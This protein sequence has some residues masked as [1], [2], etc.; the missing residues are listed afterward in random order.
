M[1]IGIFGDSFGDKSHI[2]ETATSKAWTTYIAKEFD[3]DNH[4]A[5]GSSFYYSAKLFLK[6]HHLYDKIIF[7]VTDP[8]RLEVPPNFGIN[9]KQS[10]I[11]SITHANMMAEETGNIVYKVAADYFFYFSDLDKECFFQYAAID[12][13]RSIRK[14]NILFLPCFQHSVDE[15]DRKNELFRIASLDET[16]SILE[17]SGRI[18]DT[19]HCHFNNQNN[20]IFA[21]NI[22][23]WIL[24]GV[25]NFNI[26]DYVSMPVD[27]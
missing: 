3:T 25:W 22:K 20:I 27:K 4:C 24:N 1:K 15:V 6:T 12:K 14:E 10:R 16:N 7:L 23:N 2:P 9:I 18:N 8:G 19:R 11:P 17:K 5:S 13:L 26:N 21:N